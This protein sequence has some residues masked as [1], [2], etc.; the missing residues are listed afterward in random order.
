MAVVAVFPVIVQLLRAFG[1]Q[2]CI[3]PLQ[4][5]LQEIT[6][7]VWQKPLKFRVKNAWKVHPQQKRQ[8]LVN[9]VSQYA[10]KSRWFKHRIF[11]RVGW[12]SSSIEYFTR[13][14]SLPVA[15]PFKTNWILI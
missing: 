4:K 7:T 13:V 6:L 5:K 2:L 11:Y 10:F 1:L 14:T 3:L 15:M 9:C 8:E 12:L